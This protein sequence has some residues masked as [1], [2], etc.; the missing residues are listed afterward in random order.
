MIETAFAQL[1]FAVSMLFGIPFS[2]RS[3]DRMI[4]AALET[5][6]E[7]GEIGAEGAELVSGPTL[8]EG[9]R[10]DVQLRRFRKQ[11]T[12]G[13]RETAYY[14]EVF[15]QADLDPARLTYDDIAQIPLT[16]KEAIRDNPDT[17]VRRNARHA[18]RTTTSGT[19]GRPAHV[20][21]SQYELA[22]T[23]AL[24]AMSSILD[25]SIMSE[26]IVQISSSSRATLG[27]LCFAGT[28]VRLGAL[29][30]PVG[31]V[32][33]DMTLSLLREEHHIKGKKP[34]V[35]VIF[36]YPS[37]LGEIV[38]CGLRLG[39]GPRDFG[40]ERIVAGGEIVS[41]GLKARA[42]QLFGEVRFDQG[43]GITELWP[44]GGRVCPQGHLH[45]EVSQGLIEVI[46][47]DTGAPAED[48]EAGT[49]VGTPFAPYR[50]S[51]VVLRYD[52][53]DVVRP[54][55]G[56]LDCSM[57]NLP[58]TSNLL[59]K[60]GLSVRHDAGWTFPRDVV[61]ALEAVEEVPL[62][63]RC[64]FWAVPGG[65]AVEVVARGDLV[66][67]QR[68]IEASLEKHGVPLRELRVLDDRSQLRKP[69]PWRGD[70][71][72]LTF[73]AYARPAPPPPDML[74]NSTNKNTLT[75]ALIDDRR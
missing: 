41:E 14:A 74:A 16:P 8:D 24:G 6:R 64:G 52:T 35:S 75:G 22:V 34:H 7:F 32:E 58:A 17:F 21:F 40:L 33:P 43:Y 31:L 67:V 71:R 45:F 72:E 11:A 46:A 63:A 70:L 25:N 65:V 37:Y 5:R 60:L 23:I 53:Q 42:R 1:R 61:E 4:D 18:L 51:T 26:D 55:V 69:L 10:R 48:G 3:L 73:D 50:D 36:T 56:P 59:G 29:V 62:P 30:C 20:C 9:T 68:K 54:I 47:P 15:K 27:N 19:T 2:L 13:A 38:E 66:V 57:K 49:I 44:L 28:C 39:Y 12:F